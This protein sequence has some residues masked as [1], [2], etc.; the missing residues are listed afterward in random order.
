MDRKK[1]KDENKLVEFIKEK[2][3]SILNGNVKGDEKGNWTYIGER[4]NSVIDYILV[5]EGGDI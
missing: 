5:D 4:R 3:W 2:G 1:N